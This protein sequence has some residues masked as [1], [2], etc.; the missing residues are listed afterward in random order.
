MIALSPR[1]A[2]LTIYIRPGFRAF[3]DLLQKLGPHTKSVSCLYLTNLEK[4][5][6]S[7]LESIVRQSFASMCQKY[8]NPK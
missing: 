3:A 2:G 4:N 8:G 7:V 5:D 6:V 1:K